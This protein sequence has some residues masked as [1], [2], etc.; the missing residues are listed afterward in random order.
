MVIF[1]SGIPS[2]WGLFDENDEAMNMTE[3]KNQS[4]YYT[5]TNVS[6]CWNKKSELQTSYKVVYSA[7]RIYT[8]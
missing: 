6:L 2:Y 7:E 3:T 8:A 1:F 5:F 4:L